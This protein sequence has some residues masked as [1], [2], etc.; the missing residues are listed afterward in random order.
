MGRNLICV[1]LRV[2]SPHHR[3]TV[4]TKEKNK[5][6]LLRSRRGRSPRNPEVHPLQEKKDSSDNRW[7][8]KEIQNLLSIS[9]YYGIISP[10]TAIK[11][12]KLLGLTNFRKHFISALCSPQ[13]W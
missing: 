6:E 8:R 9:H 2:K 1:S 5:T 4:S 12:R 13:S 3:K 7:E 11:K 10:E